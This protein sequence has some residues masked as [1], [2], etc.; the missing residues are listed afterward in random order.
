MVSVQSS[1]KR[2][3][4][5]VRFCLRRRSLF[6]APFA[7]VWTIVLISYQFLLLKR[8]ELVQVD[9][10]SASRNVR[11]S[12]II[13]IVAVGSMLRSD[14][15]QTQSQTFGSHRWVRHF[16]PVSELND[17]DTH[18]ALE[19]T[20]EQRQK[21]VDFCTHSDQYTQTYETYWFRKELFRPTSMETGWLCA[22]KR[23]I[24][25]LYMALEMY[26]AGVPI[27][28]YVM[29]I[30]DD[31]F[32]NI[33]AL[34]KT[35]QQFFPPHQSHVVAGCKIRTPQA[36]GFI[37]P[38]GGMGSFLTRGAIQ[39]IL[40]P[41]DCQNAAAVG[42]AFTQWFCWRLEQD[43]VGE[44]SFFTNGMSLG[45]LMY[46]Y[47]SGLPFTRVHEWNR[48]GFCFHSDHSLGYF[49]DFYHVGIPDQALEETRPSDKIRERYSFQAIP[50]I[51]ECDNLHHKCAANSRICH[52]TN[53]ELM[54]KL[55]K[56]NM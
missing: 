16:Y 19:L 56:H 13:D 37:F 11:S 43:P 50:G 30:D 1:A 46:A 29:I 28:D 14:Y 4:N 24:D 18:C 33:N 27:P 39:R 35:L 45:D 42:S 22:Q 52:Y 54:N 17:T 34:T 23:P 32:L 9:G 6:F 47:A 38:L 41:M 48:T 21:V 3:P 15:L 53:P 7:G 31:T 40:T 2:T 44:K 25:G 20:A 26:K 49:F 10:I 8:T 12:P 55:Y 5:V 51:R 36:L